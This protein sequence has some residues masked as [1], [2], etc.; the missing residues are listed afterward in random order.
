MANEG[1]VFTNEKC[2]GCNKCI[3]V[4]SC[5]GACVSHEVD[6]KNRIDVDGSRCVACGACFDV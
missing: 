3:S 5:E 6:G 1:L 2:I 4:C